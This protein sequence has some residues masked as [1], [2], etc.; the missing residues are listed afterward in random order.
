MRIKADVCRTCDED[1]FWVTTDKGRNMPVNLDPTEDGNVVLLEP[2]PRAHVL[3]ADDPAP[4]PTTARYTSH[5][6][7]CGQADVW[8]NRK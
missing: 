8:R 5:F 7:T 3:T 2:P 6:A 4:D 1:I